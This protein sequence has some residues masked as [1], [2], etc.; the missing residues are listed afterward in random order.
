MHSSDVKQAAWLKVCV[1]N[2]PASSPT[3]GRYSQRHFTQNTRLIHYRT[4]SS[5][6]YT[7]LHCKAGRWFDKP[8]VSLSL[9]KT[10]MEATFYRRFTVWAAREV[11]DNHRY[12]YICILKLPSLQLLWGRKIPRPTPLLLPAPPASPLLQL[13]LRGTGP[14]TRPPQLSPHP[15][16]QDGSSRNLGF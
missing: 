6:R 11:Q 5:V 16:V 8:G 14:W 15:T 1:L 2:Y 7:Y 13:K 9:L 10:E 3:R 4:L 12:S